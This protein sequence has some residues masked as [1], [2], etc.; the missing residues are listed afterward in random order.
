MNVL[1]KDTELEQLV[2]YGKSR[3]YEKYARDA[4]F[5]ERLVRAVNIM[6]I[7]GEA[8]ML[9]NYSYLHYEKLKHRDASSIRIMNGRIERIIFRELN[10]GIEIELLE[11]N[12]DHYGNK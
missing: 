2:L 7:V 3:K 10:N 4:K 12:N 1:F 8:R 5:T 9:A 11:L 6:R